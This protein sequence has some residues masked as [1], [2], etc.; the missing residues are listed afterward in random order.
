[1]KRG[2]ELEGVSFFQLHPSFYLR[3]K[4]SF[5]LW[6]PSPISLFCT[7]AL[8][9]C[10]GSPA[11][12]CVR[13]PNQP[14][15]PFALEPTLRTLL[16]SD[17]FPFSS[18]L[19]VE[20]T[21]TRLRLVTDLSYY[22]ISYRALNGRVYRERSIRAHHVSSLFPSLPVSSF[23]LSGSSTSYAMIEKINASNDLYEIL[24]CSKYKS[25]SKEMRKLFLHRARNVHPE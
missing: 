24:G 20:I 9:F 1:M 8:S 7:R 4:E 2:A 23:A 5:P 3:T 22:S 21:T 11:G 19:H 13:H 18:P 17:R 12:G 25:D 15:S 10:L 16:P 14:R 6:T